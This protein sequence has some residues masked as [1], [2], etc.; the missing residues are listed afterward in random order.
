MV[1]KEGENERVRAGGVRSMEKRRVY[2]RGTS[3]LPL[4]APK[5]S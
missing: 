5:F 3:Q 4:P 2:I 1:G